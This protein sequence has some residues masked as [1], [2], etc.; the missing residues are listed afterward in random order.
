MNE[1]L[2]Q[3]TLTSRIHSIEERIRTMDPQE[4]DRIVTTPAARIVQKPAR[5]SSEPVTPVKGRPQPILRRFADTFWDIGY[6]FRIP[7]RRVIEELPHDIEH[8]RSRIIRKFIRDDQSLPSSLG[9]ENDRLTEQAV[10]LQSLLQKAE[11]EREM[12]HDI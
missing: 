2:K 7:F 9:L 5:Q 8:V 6:R 1:Q 11:K 10:R 4:P 12:Q 3:T